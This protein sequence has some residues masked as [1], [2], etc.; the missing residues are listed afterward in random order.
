MQANLRFETER[1]AFRKCTLDDLD[2]LTLLFSHAETMQGYRGA[3]TPEQTLEWLNE[4][5]DTWES[6]GYGYWML[7][8]KETGEIVGTAGLH[9][10]TVDG[11]AEVEAG[12][13]LHVDHWGSGLGA[14]AA[15]LCY[16]YAINTLGLSRVI[17]LIDP[18]NSASIYLAE[19]HGLTYQRQT[20]MWGRTVHMYARTSS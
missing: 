20:A 1:L 10:Y 7:D 9:E 19:K 8:L 12:Y 18:R 11:V 13:V 14:E 15:G 2:D 3:R 5:M 17:T 16:D 6:P 4:T